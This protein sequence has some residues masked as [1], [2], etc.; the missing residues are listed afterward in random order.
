[1][2]ITRNDVA[3]VANLAKLELSEAELDKFSSQLESIIGYIDQ[4][5][6]CDVSDIE[7]SSPVPNTNIRDDEAKKIYSTETVLANAPSRSEDF[8][9]VDRVIT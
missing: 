5:S 3:H 6:A 2:A 8:F 1:M 9:R 7:Q 4:L